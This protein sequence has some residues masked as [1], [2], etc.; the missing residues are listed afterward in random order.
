MNNMLPYIHADE[1]VYAQLGRY[2][3]EL[4]IEAELSPLFEEREHG[5]WLREEIGQR[6]A[7]HA[8]RYN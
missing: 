1:V 4:L 6:L 2:C 7:Q 5:R 8:Q 3:T